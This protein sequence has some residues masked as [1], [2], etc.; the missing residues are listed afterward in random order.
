MTFGGKF[1]EFSGET[2]CPNPPTIQ[3]IHIQ[4]KIQPAMIPLKL[5]PKEK[6]F[7]TQP[8]TEKNGC[9]PKNSHKKNEKKDYRKQNNKLKGTKKQTNKQTNNFPTKKTPGQF[10]LTPRLIGT[11]TPFPSE[12]HCECC[13]GESGDAGVFTGASDRPLD[14]PGVEQERPVDTLR[15]LKTKERCQK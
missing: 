11:P 7:F 8:T 2:D 12:V 5:S 14:P 6:M 3:P 13:H 15:K 9:F 10:D 4:S 1:S